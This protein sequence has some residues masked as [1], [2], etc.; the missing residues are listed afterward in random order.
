MSP[1]GAVAEAVS[2]PVGRDRSVS[3]VAQSP[4]IKPRQQR[5]PYSPIGLLLSSTGPPQLRD[6]ER[7][8]D[9]P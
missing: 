4:S 9:H 6:E 5:L 1:F 8:Q 3:S 7:G 2:P